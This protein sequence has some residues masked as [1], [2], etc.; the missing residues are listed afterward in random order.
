VLKH[1]QS[2][3][4][5]IFA[6]TSKYIF[7][8]QFPSPADMNLSSDLSIGYNYCC[9]ALICVRFSI[10]NVISTKL[11]VTSTLLALRYAIFSLYGPRIAIFN[12]RI[13]LAVQIFRLGT[14]LGE[15][16]IQDVVIDAGGLQ[17]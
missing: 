5:L 12:S 15:F 10:P 17:D 2:E 9:L 8:A 11:A 4:G 16:E 3:E 13:R 7:Y 14:T 6:G 1:P